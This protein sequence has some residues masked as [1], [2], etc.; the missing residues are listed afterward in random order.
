M[1]VGSQVAIAICN[2]WGESELPENAPVGMIIAIDTAHNCNG[3]EDIAAVTIRW[4]NGHVQKREIFDETTEL[5]DVTPKCYANLYLFDRAYGGPEEGSWFYDTY[6]PVDGDWIDDPPA[7]GHFESEALAE[8]A[9]PA[10]EAWCKEQNSTRRS[11]SSVAS[12]GHFVV[13][14]E[15][16]PAE[17]KPR[18]RPYY[19]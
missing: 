9:L 2:Q 14:L 1:R 13:M 3:D 8:A 15:A 4:N 10:L 5:M 12:E 18:N 11:P 6:E 19:C 7:Y 17:F 16:W